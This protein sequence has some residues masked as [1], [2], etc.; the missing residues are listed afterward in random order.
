[1]D[2]EEENEVEQIK[3]QGGKYERK[4]KGSREEEG[5]EKGHPGGRK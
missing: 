4:K 1:M 3:Q 5:R 2:Q